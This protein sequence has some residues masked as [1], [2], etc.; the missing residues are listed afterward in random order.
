MLIGRRSRA[1][2]T[3]GTASPSHRRLRAGSTTLAAHGGTGHAAPSLAAPS[4]AAPSLAAPS[5]AAQVAPGSPPPPA[6][7]LVRTPAGQ[8]GR[9]AA[10]AAVRVA[11]RVAV[12][13]AARAAVRVTARAAARAA[14]RVAARVAARGRGAASPLG[15]GSPPRPKGGR[16]QAARR[17]AARRQAAPRRK[18]A[19]LVAG[20]GCC[21][22]GEAAHQG[23][24]GP[25]GT[26]AP[27][28][29]QPQEDQP[30]SSLGGPPRAGREAGAACRP[31]GTPLRPA[32]FASLAA[33]GA[34]LWVGLGLGVG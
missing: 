9:A 20:R 27:R 18:A 1:C 5:L 14:A 25:Q 11:A 15:A 6:Q 23:P 28:T 29:G 16:R 24:L 8:R 3:C 30:R 34:R 21:A 26:R 31:R 32:G 7:P 19:A 33:V 17:Q 2:G 12:R 4:L 10:R 22:W 13:V